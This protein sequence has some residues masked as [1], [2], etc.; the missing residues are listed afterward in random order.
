M[1]RLTT[2]VLDTM[3]GCPA[4]GMAVALYRL[5]A[6]GAARIGRWR[7]NADGRAD[8]PLLADDAFKP[9]AYRLV[10]SVADYFRHRG[11]ALPEPPFLDRRAGGVRHRRRRRAL[12]RAAAREPVEL[13]H[14]PRQLM[15]PPEAPFG[16]SPQGGRTCG[17]AEPDPRSRP[18]WRRF[19]PARS[20]QRRGAA[21]VDPAYLIDWANFL[22]RWLHVI[23][24]IAWIGSSFYFVFLDDSL[25]PP[26]DEALKA[27]GVTGEMWAVHGGGFYNPQKYAVGPKTMPAR[28]A[29]LVLLGEL[30]H[31]A[32]RLRAVRRAVPVER[33]VVPRRPRGARVVARGRRCGVGG[34]PRGRVARVRRDLPRG[35][36]QGGRQRGRRR[37]RR[38]AG[39]GHGGA[40]ELARVQPL[41]RPRR[42][43]RG[44]RDARHDHERQRVLRDHPRPAQGGGRPA[45]RAPARPDPR[46]ARQAAQRAQHL[47]HAAGARDDGLQPLP[48]ALPAPPECA[49]ARA[50]D[51]AR[52]AG[53]AL[54]RA[55]P[56]GAAALGDRG[57][58]RGAGGA[59]GVARRAG[60]PS[61]HRPRRRPASP[62]CRP[63]CSSAARCATTRS[64]AQKGVRL[65]T[66]RVAARRTPRRSTSRPWSRARCR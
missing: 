61:A 55:A 15:D 10:F 5:D 64:S 16:A 44:R 45:R 31:V 18:W 9:G 24:A 57:R 4:A 32:L 39:A 42:L 58:E 8:A 13:R 28:H 52:G 54:L 56:Q 62:T 35:R 19:M 7:M 63:W 12:P 25:E 46:P 14:L 11:A 49:R 17:P 43:R 40:R 30:F 36:P 51:G 66:P 21:E 23:T 38:R 27:R 33:V 20:A 59:A 50:A 1:G 60:R 34:L 47:P 2:H 41:R 22:L 37:P 26:A 29:A 53:A 3:N 6:S 48:H 65:D